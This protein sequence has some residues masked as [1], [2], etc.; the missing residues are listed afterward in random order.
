MI[1]FKEVINNY[2]K[3]ISIKKKL[4]TFLTNKGRIEKYILPYFEN[5]NIYEFNA[6]DFLNWQY[7]IES[8]NFK[9][10]Y[11][12]S[13]FYTFSDLLNYCI[14]FYNLKENIAKRIGNFKNNDIEENNLVWNLDDFKKFINVINDQK[15]KLAYKI[16]FFTGIRKGELLA[17]KVKDL[18]N[19]KLTINKTITRN[20]II[21]PPKTRSSNR[22]ISISEDLKKELNNYIKNY[23]LKN[24]DYLFNITF[25]TL[26]RK[27]DYYCEIANVKKITIHQFRHSHACLLFNYNVPIDEISFRLGHSKISMTTDIYLKYLP[28]KE[29]SVLNTLNSINC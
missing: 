15:F 14:I 20:H 29:K 5:K 26:A 10:N 17:L 2:L 1:T 8:Y 19:N 28:K 4:N 23:R 9:Y 13:L 18:N 25:T 22:I 11:K 3:Y 21:Q 24:D 27:K 16:L 12:S 6:Q 7:I